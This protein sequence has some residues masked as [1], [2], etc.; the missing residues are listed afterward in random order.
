[1]SEMKYGKI[2]KKRNK[3]EKVLV[4]YGSSLSLSSSLA[5]S[6]LYFLHLFIVFVSQR[7]RIHWQ[8]SEC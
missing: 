7:K 8:L 3:K 6:F 4:I 1:M 2:Q 5:L